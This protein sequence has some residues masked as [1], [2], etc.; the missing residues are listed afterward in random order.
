M[1]MSKD[2]FTKLKAC[3]VDH[4]QAREMFDTWWER[5][6]NENVIGYGSRLLPIAQNSPFDRF[7]VGQWL[8]TER[9]EECFHPW[10]RCPMS[11]AQMLN[12]M[13]FLRNPTAPPLYP[14]ANLKVLA[15]KFG[16][17]NKK[18]HDATEDCLTTLEVYKRMIHQHAEIV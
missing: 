15:A 16:I 3:P 14:L 2:E 9:M 1:R 6:H 18:A 11:L 4:E 12:D 5:L 17:E 10:H 8:G 7:M 13:N